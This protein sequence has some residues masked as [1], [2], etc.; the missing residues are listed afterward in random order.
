[1][2]SQKSEFFL[3]S[4]SVDTR[5]AS[6]REQR[7]PTI[8][9]IAGP[10]PPRSWVQANR[11]NQEERRNAA[12]TTSEERS[13][14]TW[15]FGIISTLLAHL[16]RTKQSIILENLTGVPRLG[17]LCLLVLIEACNEDDFNGHVVPVVPVHLRRELMWYTSVYSPLPYATLRALCSPN[18]HVLEELILVGPI[19]KVRRDFVVLD[20]HSAHNPVH[21]VDDEWDAPSYDAISTLQPLT[22]LIII[23]IHLPTTVFLTLPRTLSRLS[24]IG[25]PSPIPLHRLPQLCPI[26]IFLDLSHNAWLTTD[27]A[28]PSP[29]YALGRVPWSKWDNLKVVALRN[30]GINDTAHSVVNRDRWDDIEIML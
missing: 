21:T 17:L 1:M 4:L 15:R 2:P 11:N 10:P 23:S 8:Y 5:N 12:H 14:P 27:T 29:L 26:M 19:H 20:P 22:T 16:P 9:R 18:G 30:C 13:S 24:L 7:S 6:E 28:A 3:P 25:L